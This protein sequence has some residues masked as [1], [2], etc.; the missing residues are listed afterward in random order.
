MSLF[1]S[2][3]AI[4]THDTNSITRSNHYSTTITDRFVNSAP[5][6]ACMGMET[7]EGNVPGIVPGTI[8]TPV[9][10]MDGMITGPRIGN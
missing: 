9:E 2:F 6:N 7:G 1:S 4:R 8:D 5:I 10:G 3:S